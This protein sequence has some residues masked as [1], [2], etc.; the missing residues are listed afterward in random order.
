MSVYKHG[1]LIRQCFTS[2]RTG[3]EALFYLADFWISAYFLLKSHTSFTVCIA[4]DCL[5]TITMIPFRL[6]GRIKKLIFY[7]ID[8]V[9]QRFSNRILNRLYHLADRIACRFA[10]T[11]WVLSPKMPEFRRA[12]GVRYMA[13]SVTLP[14]GANLERIRPLPISK[15]HRHQLVFA[16]ILLE[17]QGLQLVMQALPEIIKNIKDVQLMVV[18]KGEYEQTLKNLAHDLHVEK[19]INFLGFVEKHSAVER[20][21]CT[22]AIGLAPYKPT[23]DSY[24]YFTDPG[25]PKLYLGCGLPVVITDVPAIAHVIQSH[26]AGMTVD[27]KVKSITKALLTLLTDESL[28]AKYRNNALELAKTYNTDSLIH[29]ALDKTD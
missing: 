5:N 9:P 2:T 12:N 27:Y 16:G 6:L 20:L 13:P 14:M 23:P 1:K 22:S 10:D 4:L 26:H 28:Y 25:K 8:Y 19:Y 24:T 21:L 7:T 15:I 29:K 18:G 3:P 17:K 11:I